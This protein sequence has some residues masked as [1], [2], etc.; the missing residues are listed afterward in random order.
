MTTAPQPTASSDRATVTR[1]V[2]PVAPVRGS[3]PLLPPLPFGPELLGGI[4][5]FVGSPGVVVPPGG[6]VVSTVAAFT[7]TWTSAEQNWPARSSAL[8]WNERL[9]AQPAAGD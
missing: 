1:G 8:Y 9:P 5:G 6:V 4:V 7:S 2:T 3:V